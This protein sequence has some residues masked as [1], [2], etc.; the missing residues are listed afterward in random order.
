MCHLICFVMTN[1]SCCSTCGYGLRLLT[2]QSTAVGYHNM[3]LHVSVFSNIENTEV[4][5]VVDFMIV[6]VLYKQILKVESVLMETKLDIDVCYLVP[7]TG[8]NVECF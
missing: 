7:S 2:F 3:S 8:Q 4:H 5:S 1:E 6:L